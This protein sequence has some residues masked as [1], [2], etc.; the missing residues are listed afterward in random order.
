MAEERVASASMPDVT[1]TDSTNTT[2]PVALARRAE[3]NQHQN[4]SA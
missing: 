4:L 1:Q 3:V 2:M